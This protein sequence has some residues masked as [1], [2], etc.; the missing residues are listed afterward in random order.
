MR[1]RFNHLRE[2]KFRRKFRDTLNPLCNRGNEVESTSHYLLRCCLY[3]TSRKTLYDNLKEIL[4]QIPNF[5]DDKFVNLLLYGNY[6]YSSE[7]TAPVLVN[8]INFLKASERFDISL[9]N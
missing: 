6:M 2:Y 5:P 7:Q 1:L 3:S 4:G 8:T 9:L